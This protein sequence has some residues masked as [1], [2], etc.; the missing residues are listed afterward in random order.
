[1]TVTRH[2][3]KTACS[4]S[5]AWTLTYVYAEQT[6]VLGPLATHAEPHS[7]DLCEEHAGRLT[8]P[9]GWDVV[10]IDLPEGETRAPADDLA[11]LADAVREHRSGIVHVEAGTRDEQSRA[12]V[13][14]IARR[15]HLRVLR[16]R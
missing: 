12:A 14:E 16:D 4:R 5:A 8:V 10:R 11:A 1:M 6:A 9:R 3:S 2:C 15:G 7:Y 13:I